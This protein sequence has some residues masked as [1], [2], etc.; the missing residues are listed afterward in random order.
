MYGFPMLGIALVMFLTACGG[1]GGSS[2]SSPP[3]SLSYTGSTSPATISVANGSVLASSVLG[4]S[5]STNIMTGVSV[6]PATH[7]NMSAYIAEI[8]NAARQAPAHASTGVVPAAGAVVT[9]PATTVP[10]TSGGTLT[11]SGQVD[12]VIM[13]GSMTLVFANYSNG[14]MRMSGTVWMSFSAWDAANSLPLTSTLTFTNVQMTDISSN[15]SNRMDGSFLM[16]LNVGANTETLTVNAIMEE[17]PSG[18]QAK[19]QNFVMTNTYDNVLSPTTVS[20][21]LSGRVFDSQYG[22]VDVST[23]SPMVITNLNTDLYPASGQIV[24]T[25]A[26]GTAGGAT[27]V[28]LTAILNLQ[29]Q[30][31]IDVDGDNVYDNSTQYLWANL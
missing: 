16:Q 24:L 4:G 18:R 20:E 14:V 22:Y 13:T 19:L 1:G 23:V 7:R 17:S 9:I 8:A 28:R 25:G 27:K 29:V 26:N 3:A 12:N 31:D 6:S 21:A 11:M 30:V 10:G 2:S 15:I 5:S